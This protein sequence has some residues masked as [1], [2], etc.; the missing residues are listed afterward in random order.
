M[1]DEPFITSM[2]ALQELSVEL[3][4]VLVLYLWAKYLVSVTLALDLII[5]LLTIFASRHMNQHLIL[6]P[7]GDQI[8]Y[9]PPYSDQQ[10]DRIYQIFLRGLK[11]ERRQLGGKHPR[12]LPP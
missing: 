8:D 2:K 9:T 12:R 10:Q 1:N 6:K 11:E 3:W 5:I 7:M 4:A